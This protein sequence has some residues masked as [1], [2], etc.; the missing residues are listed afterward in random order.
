MTTGN[1]LKTAIFLCSVIQSTPTSE[2]GHRFCARPVR[3][4][5]MPGNDS[6]FF[7]WF[8]EK[9]VVPETNGLVFE[10]LCGGHHKPWIPKHIMKSVCDTPGTQGMK[11]NG[12]RIGGFI[13][14]IFIKEL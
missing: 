11:Q 12:G 2:M 8:V 10:Q 7:R 3:I 1:I 4:I 9:L 14:V 13:A 6:S 5:L